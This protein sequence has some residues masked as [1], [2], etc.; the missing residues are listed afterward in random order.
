[1]ASLTE[2]LLAHEVLARRGLGTVTELNTDDVRDRL[3]DTW[4]SIR[5]TVPPDLAAPLLAALRV[6]WTR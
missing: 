2:R 1:M 6:L 5:R 3:A 4:A